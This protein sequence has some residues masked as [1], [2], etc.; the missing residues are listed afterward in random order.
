MTELEALTIVLEM[1]KWTKE[2]SIDLGLSRCSE[3]D[4]AILIV[5][6]MVESKEENLL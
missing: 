6:K 5:S 4:E 1:A 3:E 2:M